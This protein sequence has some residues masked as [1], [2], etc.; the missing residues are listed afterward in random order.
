MRVERLPVTEVWHAR[1]RRLDQP[2]WVM[3]SQGMSEL[4]RSIFRD[5]G[6]DKKECGGCDGGFGGG[7]T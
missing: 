2:L 1:L 5:T 3:R 6:L 7:R 4:G